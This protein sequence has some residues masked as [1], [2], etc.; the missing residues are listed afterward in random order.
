MYERWF[1]KEQLRGSTLLL[2][3][4]EPQKISGLPI[5]QHAERLDPPQEGVLTRDGQFVHRYYYRVAYGYKP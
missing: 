2:V 5:E 1:P 4:V 3:A